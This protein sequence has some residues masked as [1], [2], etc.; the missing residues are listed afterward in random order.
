LIRIWDP[1]RLS[2]S[3]PLEG[4]SRERR[5][6]TVTR[7]ID[8]CRARSGYLSDDRPTVSV[9]RDGIQGL[10]VHFEAASVGPVCSYRACR[11]FSWTA[12]P[13][14]RPFTPIS[15]GA[16]VSAVLSLDNREKL[17]RTLTI[18]NF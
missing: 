2:I 18:S 7:R 6:G 15:T 1:S 14:A 3:C 5:L 8:C 4:T 17:Q 11:R 12:L 9:S 16:I 13:R 10:P